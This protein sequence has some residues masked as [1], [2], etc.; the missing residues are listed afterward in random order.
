M[1]LVGKKPIEI[2]KGVKVQ[3]KDGVVLVEGPKGK[4]SYKL[5]PRIKSEVKG[6]QVIVTRIAESKID[7][8]MHGLS[9]ALIY[10][11]VFGVDQ[12]YKKELEIL[13]TGYKVGVQGQTLN[14]NV[15][16]SHPVSF[17]IPEGI[18]IEAPKPNQLIVTGIDKEKVGEIAA[19]I[20]AVSPPEPYKGKGIRY[21]GEHV[22]KKVGKAQATAK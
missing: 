12:G 11:M 15:G 7:K 4:L 9:R 5:S 20:R 19:E 14:M 17:S 22:K 1:S 2:P 16:Y 6:N 8:S 18:K 3:V 13:G 10:N 21:L